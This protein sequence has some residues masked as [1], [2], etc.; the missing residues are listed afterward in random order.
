MSWSE[1]CP[2]RVSGTLE[3]LGYKPDLLTALSQAGTTP[4]GRTAP[5]SQ[6]GPNPGEM[7]SEA[8][9]TAPA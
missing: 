4:P 9:A 1:R 6:D 2:L 5:I 7:I 3:P 8:P